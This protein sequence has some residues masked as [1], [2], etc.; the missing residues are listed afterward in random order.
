MV[1]P[2]PPSKF[3][4]KKN[5][6]IT[7]CDYYVR[8]LIFAVSMC[9]LRNKIMLLARKDTAECTYPSTMYIWSHLGLAWLIPMLILIACVFRYNPLAQRL[10]NRSVTGVKQIPLRNHLPIFRF[11]KFK[12]KSPE[13]VAPPALHLLKVISFTAL[14]SRPRRS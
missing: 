5:E 4:P 10:E 8:S 1:V 11:N 14:L 12:N 7:A 9:F 6:N 3:K 13:T 2:P